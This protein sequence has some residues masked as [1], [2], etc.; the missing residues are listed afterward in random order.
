MRVKNF[1]ILLFLFSSGCAHKAVQSLGQAE[2]VRLEVA[3][4][5]RAEIWSGKMLLQDLRRGKR[6]VV[7]WDFLGLG[8]T[9]LRA[10]FTGPLGVSLAHLVLDS[11]SMTLLLPREKK[12]YSGIA[13]SK[14]IQRLTKMSIEPGLLKFFVWER[15][16]ELYGLVCESDLSLRF[17]KCQ[18][19]NF[20]MT[21]AERDSVKKRISV[22]SNHWE[23]Q[24]LVKDYKTKPLSSDQNISQ[25]DLGSEAVSTN[26]F[27]LPVPEGYQYIQ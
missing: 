14:V 1:Y 27:K 22:K 10:D 9:S 21:F 15:N 13:N 6:D 16:P 24:F 18:H 20:T 8:G 4:S 25:A 2:Q 19:K 11:D 3:N 7:D 23:I 12:F 26:V 5:T 17:T